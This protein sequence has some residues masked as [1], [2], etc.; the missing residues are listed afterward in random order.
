MTMVALEST[1]AQPTDS[2][3]CIR[4]D[5]IYLGFVI[6]G[7]RWLRAKH[8]ICARIIVLPPD[9]RGGG[10]SGRD[11]RDRVASVIYD[12][13]DWTQPIRLG[14]NGLIRAP[15]KHRR[16]RRRRHHLAGIMCAPFRYEN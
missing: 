14:A 9:R 3:S 16:G 1:P 8:S 12:W 2:S 13:P 11:S 6:Y 15:P 4:L 5:H 7:R 10:H